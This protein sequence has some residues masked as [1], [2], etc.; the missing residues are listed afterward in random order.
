MEPVTELTTT[1][2]H[3]HP[4]T[5]KGCALCDARTIQVLT[6][7]GGIATEG[8]IE[9]A[10]AEAASNTFYNE[11]RIS[12]SNRYAAESAAYRAARNIK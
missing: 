9:Q 6:E 12:I 10:I 3:A 2:A 1:T 11:L 8:Q 4:A 5:A 7:L